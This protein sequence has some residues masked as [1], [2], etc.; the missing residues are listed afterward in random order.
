MSPVG[1]A[2]VEDIR[3]ALARTEKLEP[4]ERSQIRTALLEH[5]RDMDARLDRHVV[6]DPLGAA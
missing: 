3:A 4:V 2:V 6:Q 5:L 1:R